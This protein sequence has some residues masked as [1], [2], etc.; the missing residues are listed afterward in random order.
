MEYTAERAADIQKIWALIKDIKIAMLVSE[1]QGVLRSRPMATQ[2]HEFD[3]NLWFFT[4]DTAPKVGEITRC[5]Q[6]NVAFSDPDH[7]QYVSV[8]GEASVVH[9]HQKMTEFWDPSYKAWFTEGLNDPDIALIKVEVETAEYWTAP[10]SK[11]VQLFGIAKANLT[12]KEY[13]QGN[14]DKISL[15]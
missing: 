6:V 14:H 10:A 11:V 5:G 7:Q 9:D 4:R 2:T 15:V 13:D 1:E 8:S 3:G 12:G